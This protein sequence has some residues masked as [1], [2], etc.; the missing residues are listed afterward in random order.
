[1]SV[2]FKINVS[3]SRLFWVTINLSG[4]PPPPELKSSLYPGT[5]A[6]ILLRVEFYFIQFPERKNW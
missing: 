1:M 6:M 4:P 2:N 3:G 5:S